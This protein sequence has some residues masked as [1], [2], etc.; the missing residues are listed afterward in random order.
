MTAGSGPHAPDAAGSV[1]Q[2]IRDAL[3]TQDP[4]R[5][6][7][8]AHRL[9]DDLRRFAHGNAS[10][11]PSRPHPGSRR[12]RGR[13]PPDGGSGADRPPNVVIGSDPPGATLPHENHQQAGMQHAVWPRLRSERLRRHTGQTGVDIGDG[14]I[15][16][17][18]AQLPGCQGKL[19]SP[20]VSTKDLLV[21]PI[22]LRAP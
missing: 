15:R 3:V 21:S 17:K 20:E 4:I 19:A 5:R 18:E 22:E 11:S 16:A 13:V 12:R 2:G 9:L 14:D 7:Q 8:V 1:S 6:H 10:N